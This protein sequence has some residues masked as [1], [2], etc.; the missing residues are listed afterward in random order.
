MSGSMPSTEK[1]RRAGTVTYSAKDPGQFVPSPFE[2][3]TQQGVPG[4]AV[5][6]VPAVH[7]RVD[8]DVLADAEALGPLAQRVDR[9][10]QF[11]TGR[12]RELGEEL[13]VVDVQVGAADA[14]LLHAY[15][16]LTRSGVRGRDLPDR[17]LARGVVDNGFH[18]D[19]YDQTPAIRPVR[20]RHFLP[21]HEPRD[22]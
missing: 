1:T 6:A 2:V 14:G 22:H 16:H 3:G 21:P 13:A 17:V 7:V 18:Q 20:K 19:C 8:R 9:S 15:P 5:L 11:V 12:Q 10:D 4:P